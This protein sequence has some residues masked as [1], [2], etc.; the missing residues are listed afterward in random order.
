MDC[1]FAALKG[2]GSCIAIKKH[3]N[4]SY[5]CR[6]QFDPV[7]L[8]TA[9]KAFASSDNK[10]TRETI[11]PLKGFSLPYNLHFILPSALKSLQHL[12]QPHFLDIIYIHD[13]IFKSNCWIFFSMLYILLVLQSWKR[14]MCLKRR[15]FMCMPW[16][17]TRHTN[18]NYSGRK[19]SV[20][21]QIYGWQISK[22]T[23]SADHRQLSGWILSISAGLSFGLGI[24][25]HFLS[26]AF[27]CSPSPFLDE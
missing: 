4:W 20:I 13:N 17:L 21:V 14:S 9:Q 1:I 2:R 3:N 12:R 25:F 24:I 10:A 26:A 15:V 19:K 27:I 8:Q 6:N 7:M 18:Y 23:G 16:A 11:K 22:V 5:L